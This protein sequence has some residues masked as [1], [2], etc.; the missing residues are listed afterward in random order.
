MAIKLR[1]RETDL[2]SSFIYDFSDNFNNKI[3][4]ESLND[5]SDEIENDK[6]YLFN[7]FNCNSNSNFTK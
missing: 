6:I 1:S 4:I 7:G 3:I 5:F 2:I